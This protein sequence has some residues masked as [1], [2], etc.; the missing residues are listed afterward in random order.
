V[1]VHEYVSVK[2]VEF[3]SSREIDVLCRPDSRSEVG[4]VDAEA[5]WLCEHNDIGALLSL[6]GNVSAYGD[7]ALWGFAI[8]SFC[9]NQNF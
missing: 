5:L 9:H 2:V 8:L 1:C 4:D 7:F 6:L 3:V